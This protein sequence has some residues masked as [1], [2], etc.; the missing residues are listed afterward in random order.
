MTIFP[1]LD[2]PLNTAGSAPLAVDQQNHSLS[3]QG[4]ALSPEP[5]IFSLTGL[6]HLGGHEYPFA[7]MQFF[8]SP[9]DARES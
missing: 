7:P 4:Q 8:S 5:D 1:V 3:S 6:D 2:N 9:P